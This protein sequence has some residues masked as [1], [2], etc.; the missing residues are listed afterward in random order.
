M[1]R[2]GL[3]LTI[4]ICAFALQ[5]LEYKLPK[6][7]FITSGDGDGQGTV[8]DGVVLALQEF[9]K[10]GAFVRLENRTVLYNTEELDK[11]QIMII[12]TTFGYHDADR[13]YSLSF[14]SQ[15]EMQNISNWVKQG[16]TLVSDAYLGRNKINGEDR[17][18]KDN[19]LTRQN[20]KLADCF[21]VELKELN[22]QNYSIES[23]SEN[24]WEGSITPRF[25]LPEWTPV[26]TKETGRNLKTLAVW[27]GD[28][29]Y[30]AITQNSFH[31]GKAILL[32]SFNLIHP[33]SDGG[34]SSVEEIQ[35]F[36]RYVYETYLQERNYA[37]QLNPWKNGASTALCLSF[38]NGGKLPEYSRIIK[39]LN[40]EKLPATYF[41][42]NNID[43]EI[44]ILLEKQRLIKIESHSQTNP[45]F[46]KISYSNALQEIQEN[47][48]NYGN[49]M[50]GFRF[51]FL[52]NSFWGMKALDD[53]DFSYDSSIGLNHLEFYRG[54]LF[55]YNI[56][57]FKD[58]YF[59]ALDL[60]EI[61][62]NFHDDWYYFKG[63]HDGKSYTEDDRK[64][65]AA[66]FDAY[67][68]TMWKR[69][70][71][72]ENGLMVFVGHGTYSGMSDVTMQPLKH[73]VFEASND[74]AW[75]TNLHEIATYWNQLR[76]LFI[77]VEETDKQVELS[78]NLP[79]GEE[80]T[81]LSFSLPSK[82]EK[83]IFKGK[84]EV[85]KVNGELSL[86]L[87]SVKDGDA[88]IIIY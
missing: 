32:S 43:P 63:V 48:S 50:E 1:K 7:L 85:K 6:V 74:G 83:I 58:G 27:S 44:K 46:R 25:E 54:S 64:E 55:P 84:Y 79:R 35:D 33:A 76:D 51:P 41:L 88:V 56:P 22:M 21:G 13:R 30:P 5:G 26:V 53:L 87:K 19:T 75:L 81:G 45:D 17:I 86:I 16:G 77:E 8:S 10:T 61:S 3:L 38:N 15:T 37:I 36:Y 57:I 52:N 65:D 39:Y 12:P 20:W 31:S 70:V 62:Q 82:P 34:F 59:Q 49:E 78:I 11:F 60:L 18:S 66:K 29:N 73:L 2:A 42:T 47:N 28:Q 72:P 9:N 80:L 4:L 67:L 14:L 68:Q 71:K 23:E 69:A 24:I 40:R